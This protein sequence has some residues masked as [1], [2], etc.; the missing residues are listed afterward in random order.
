MVF[1]AQCGHSLS[2]LLVF[3]LCKAKAPPGIMAPPTIVIV[4]DIVKY[5]SPH[6]YPADKTLAAFASHFQ[7]VEKLSTQALT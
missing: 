5:R 7:R 1:P 4:L 2:D 3:K 6:Y